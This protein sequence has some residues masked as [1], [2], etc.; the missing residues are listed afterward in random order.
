MPSCKA[1]GSLLRLSMD[2]YIVQQV[3]PSKVWGLSISRCSRTSIPMTV[4]IKDSNKIS[5]RPP[6]SEQDVLSRGLNTDCQPRLPEG[7]HSAAGGVEGGLGQ[8]EWSG[9]SDWQLPRPRAFSFKSAVARIRCK[10]TSI[11][12]FGLLAGDFWLRSAGIWCM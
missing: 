1:P 11:P 8:P 7:K 5:Y 12:G 2:P 9:K 10:H 3:P 4:T 6:Y